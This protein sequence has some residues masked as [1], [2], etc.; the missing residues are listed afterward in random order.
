MTNSH[1][2]ACLL[3]HNH[4][5]LLSFADQGKQTAVFRLRLQQIN[6]V[7]RLPFFMCVC[8]FVCGGVRVWVIFLFLFVNLYLYLQAAVSNGKQKNGSP[9]DFLNPFT[10][11]SSCQR[12]FVVCPFV[13][14][15]INR[16]YPFANGLNGL[17]GLAHLCQW[18]KRSRWPLLSN[19][20]FCYKIL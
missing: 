3:K 14:E 18:P 6:K 4:R 19:I 9:C 7:C 12:K 5:L 17:N 13:D 8:V 11:G 2:G 16:S 10:V 1:R 20:R 15:K